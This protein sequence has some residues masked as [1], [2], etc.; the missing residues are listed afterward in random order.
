MAVVVPPRGIPEYTSDQSKHEHLPSVPLRM[1]VVGPSGSGKTMLLVSMI[2]DLY[3]RPSGDSVWKRIYVFSPSVNADPVW[4]PVKKF[5]AETLQVPHDEQWCWDHYDPQ[6]MLE[7][8]ETQRKVTAIAKEK[9]LKKLFGILIVVDDFADDPR[10]SRQDRLLHSLYTRGRHAF[11][12]T[13]TATQKYRALSNVI[14]VNAT[15]LIVFRLRSLAEQEAIVEENSAVHDKKILTSMVH[16]ATEEPYSFLFINL[17][18][19]KPEDMFWLRFEKRLV[20]AAAATA[21][22]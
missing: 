14:R 9:G 11:I 2:C 17:A 15:A 5:V 18:A 3:R 20:A 10:M 16:R 22:S 21:P 6:A 7:I 13:I 4:L 1:V 19:K 8:I 12:S